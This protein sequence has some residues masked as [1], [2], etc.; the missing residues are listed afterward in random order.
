[1]YPTT[2]CP[3][4]R[5]ILCRGRTEEYGWGDGTSDGRRG[6]WGGFN[7][8]FKGLYEIFHT[9][10]NGTVTLRMVAV[11]MRINISNIKTYNN[12]NVEGR[13]PI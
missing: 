10:T 9:W 4:G 12:P 1:M 5:M 8:P 2:I 7:A 11:T 3:C 13:D 6:G